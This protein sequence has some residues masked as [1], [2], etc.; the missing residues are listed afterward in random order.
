[1]AIEHQYVFERIEC[2][3]ISYKAEFDIDPGG[4]VGI[5]IT[6]IRYGRS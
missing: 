3:A 5:A 1:M 6:M 4:L 2:T